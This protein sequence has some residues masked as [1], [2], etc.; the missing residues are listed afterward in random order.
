MH[1]NQTK[2]SRLLSPI[3]KNLEGLCVFVVFCSRVYNIK[4]S[5]FYWIGGSSK[6]FQIFTSI[7]LYDQKRSVLVASVGYEYNGIH[8]TSASHISFLFYFQMVKQL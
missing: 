3:F 2:I 8:N 4:T 7:A 5:S 1:F 6:Q